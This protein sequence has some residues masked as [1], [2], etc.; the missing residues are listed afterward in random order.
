M[1]VISFSCV[2]MYYIL[3]SWID[4]YRFWYGTQEQRNTIL[5][6]KLRWSRNMGKELTQT[7]RY[8][9]MIEQHSNSVSQ[10]P[11]LHIHVLLSDLHG[12]CMYMYRYMYYIYILYTVK[13]LC[14]M[15]KEQS[16][17]FRSHVKYKYAI[18]IFHSSQYACKV[19]FVIKR[20]GYT[21]ISKWKQILKLQWTFILLHQVIS[22]TSSKYM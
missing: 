6:M 5:K 21:F 3:I 22:R 20:F 10:T 7:W 14:W 4:V 9:L 13:M 18:K 12:Y 15:D 1:P 17:F 2:Y 8:N 16:V 11:D 19:K